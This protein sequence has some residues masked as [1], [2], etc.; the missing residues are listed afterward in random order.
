MASQKTPAPSERPASPA[1][2]E[3]EGHVELV[4]LEV[5]TIDQIVKHIVSS[6]QS[7]TESI[8]AFRWQANH[9]HDLFE[10]LRIQLLKLYQPKIRRV[11]YDYKSGIVYLDIMAESPFHYQVHAGLRDDL[12]AS[13]KKSIA[14]TKDPAIRELIGLVV[15]QGTADIR[16]D[17]KLFKQADSES[18]PHVERKADQYIDASDNKIQVVLILKLQYRG[19]KKAWVSLLTADG[20]LLQHDLCHDDD[21]DRQPDGQVELYLSDFIGSTGLPPAYCRPS[22]TESATGITRS[23]TITLTYER[24]RAIFHNARCFHNPTKFPA[25]TRCKEENPYEQAERRVAEAEAR[26]QERIEA[27]RRVAEAVNKER[28]E[29]ERRKEAEVEQ[30]VAIELARRLA[31]SRHEA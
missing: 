28:A 19:M 17:G 4:W 9:V 15:E 29:A 12:K 6:R 25:E 20:W 30:R 16:V 14:Q 7:G 23:P 10:Q 5:S 21:L 2:S 31:E 8:I 27:D 24:L 13:I 1:S 18:R 26:N 3:D 22:T 11:E